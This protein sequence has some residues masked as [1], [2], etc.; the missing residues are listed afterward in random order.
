MARQLCPPTAVAAQ[1]TCSTM[2][3]VI[4]PSTM[5]SVKWDSDTGSKAGSSVAGTLHAA[6]CLLVRPEHRLWPA[7][8]RS[9]P[10][11]NRCL[12]CD[13]RRL[14]QPLPELAGR[15]LRQSSPAT[16]AGNAHRHRGTTSRP[17]SQATQ[18]HRACASGILGSHWSHAHARPSRPTASCATAQNTPSKSDVSSCWVSPAQ[19][20]PS[21]SLAP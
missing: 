14:P 10:A 16:T 21:T 15:H 6:S 5:R 7:L 3:T 19:Q 13:P 9:S 4:S 11:K 20:L 2:P 18:P 12:Q 1:P 8:T 17:C